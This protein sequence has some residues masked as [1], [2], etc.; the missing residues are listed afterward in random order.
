MLCLLGDFQHVER[1]I[2]ALRLNSVTRKL[3]SF[4]MRFV[5]HVGGAL[6]QEFHSQWAEETLSH[7]SPLNIEMNQEP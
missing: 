2:E 6:S 4:S 1:L 5:S 3:R 7:M